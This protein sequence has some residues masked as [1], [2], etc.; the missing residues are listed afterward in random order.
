MLEK[1]FES[2]NS[3]FWA[4]FTLLVGIIVAKWAEFLSVRFLEKLKINQLFER[5]GWEGIFSKFDSK[6]KIS[7]LFSFFVK[8]FFILV[9]L[10][11]SLEILK[12]SLA[13]QFLEKIVLYFPNIFLS[14]FIF[15]VAAFL[16]DLSQKTFVATLEREKITYSAFLGRVISWFV[17]GFAAF[18]ILYQLQI[19]KDLVLIIF[20]GFVL[21]FSLIFGISFGIGGKKLAE[22]ILKEFEEK[23][24]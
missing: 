1:T 19:V 16:V 3:I 11:L 20:A 4:G 14:F 22:K 5:L 13:A 2:Y 6:L 18:A 7:N 8:W 17:W 12:L 24:K 21:I 23:L 9:F 10:M 15:L